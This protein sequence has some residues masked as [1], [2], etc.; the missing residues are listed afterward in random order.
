MTSPM[1]SHSPKSKPKSNPKKGKG[2]QT[3]D[4]DRDKP[5]IQT[6]DMELATGPVTINERKNTR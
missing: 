2:N 3:F 5:R 6:S 4:V 1:P